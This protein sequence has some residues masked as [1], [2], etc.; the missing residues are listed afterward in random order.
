MIQMWFVVILFLSSLNI[1]KKN[2]LPLGDH[3]KYD[4]EGGCETF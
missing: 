3:I 2:N 4:W 1:A